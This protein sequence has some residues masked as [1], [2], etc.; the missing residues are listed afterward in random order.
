MSTSEIHDLLASKGFERL[1]Q[2]E[3][4]EEVEEDSNHAAPHDDEF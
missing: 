4:I 3:V 1:S 2:A